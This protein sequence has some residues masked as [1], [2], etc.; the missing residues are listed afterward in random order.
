M[1]A[2]PVCVQ[3]AGFSRDSI[4]TAVRSAIGAV[5]GMEGL[6]NEA[7]VLIKPNLTSDKP[8]VDSGIV[9]NPYV[10]EGVLAYLRDAP[11]GDGCR[12][13]I[14]E[15]DSDGTAKRA[16]QRFGLQEMAAHYGVDLISLNSAPYLKLV[17]PN[18]RIRSLALPRILFESTHFVN[19]ATLKRH[20]HER[21][22]C[23]WKNM[24]GI[25][26][27]LRERVEMH[28]FLAEALFELNTAVPPSL[29]VVDA[30]TCLQGAGPLEGYPL[31]LGKV[32]ASRDI[33]SV[34]CVAARMM[35]E[36]PARIP[37]LRYALRKV[38]QTF[39]PDAVPILGV[40]FEVTPF[41]FV[42]WKAYALYRVGLRV[43]RLA[44]Y[45]NNLATFLW[46]GG[47]AM[48]IGTVKEFSGGGVQTLRG[49]LAM[50]RDFLLR[51]EVSK[52]L[53]G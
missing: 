44:L 34:D 17:V 21:M 15:S 31:K 38:R 37:E 8:S 35:G 26:A 48:R 51:F 5:G 7:V 1:R 47:Y 32:L 41:S 14:I 40:A 50:A 18:G 19:V 16:F 53:H 9:T 36:D 46:L 42:P 52:K 43:R 12:I 10:I 13:A 45:L 23:C 11:G 27:S 20:I 33:L 6:S 4:V 28:P 29:C 30:I 22:T 49:S 2:S 39:R 25:P 24:W 3:K